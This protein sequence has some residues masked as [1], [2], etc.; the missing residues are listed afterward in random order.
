MTAFEYRLELDYWGYRISNGEGLVSYYNPDSD[1]NIKNP[2]IKMTVE[3]CDD[4]EKFY[5]L[6]CDVHVGAASKDNSFLEHRD[7]ILRGKDT[8]WKLVNVYIKSHRLTFGYLNTALYKQFD[9]YE[10][11]ERSK[12]K[13]EYSED[14]SCWNRELFPSYYS[15]I[16]WCGYNFPETDLRFETFTSEGA[17]TNDIYVYICS[18]G[19]ISLTEIGGNKE[20]Q[21]DFQN[22]MWKTEVTPVRVVECSR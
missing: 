5:E 6:F 10:A 18:N 9:F 8:S 20:R 14:F 15:Q 3:K 11:A 7:D 16:E 22:E 12:A 4:L 13:L 1:S 21:F 2:G 17:K 19:H